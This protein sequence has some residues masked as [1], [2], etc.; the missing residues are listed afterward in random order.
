VS[1]PFGSNSQD[2]PDCRSTDFSAADRGLSVRLMRHDQP[3]LYR[4]DTGL[5]LMVVLCRKYVI[6]SDGDLMP[7]G[8]ATVYTWPR[9]HYSGKLELVEGRVI[10][11]LNELG[12]LI[13]CHRNP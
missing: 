10:A 4:P 13:Q 7:A 8:V 6:L 12:I 9:S 11:L 1:Q 5:M 2:I 3:P